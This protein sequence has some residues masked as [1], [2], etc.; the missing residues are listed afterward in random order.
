MAVVNQLVSGGGTAKKDLVWE[1][2]YW[3]EAGYTGRGYNSYVIT[4]PNVR[5]YEYILVEFTKTRAENI[6]YQALFKVSDIMD[7]F[8]S[9]IQQSSVAI[10][11]R[12][13]SSGISYYYRCLNARPSANDATTMTMNIVDA[14][15]QESSDTSEIYLLP[16]RV[17]GV[18]D[19]KFDNIKLKEALVW[20][21]PNPNTDFDITEIT[22]VDITE[23]DYLRI[24]FKN[25]TTS[26]TEHEVIGKTTDMLYVD[27]GYARPI[28]MAGIYNSSTYTRPVGTSNGHIQ[29]L[30][31]YTLSTGTVRNTTMIP[32]RIYGLKGTIS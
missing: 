25:S 10:T 28:A 31:A 8:P 30:K 23:F 3:N 17:Y 11:G 5:T 1:N 4:I 16:Y 21:N 22:N 18:G 26:T 15:K 9:N 29:I 12:I 6:V 24:V 27:G 14:V 13:V 20:E 32:L 7:R 19:V 2:P